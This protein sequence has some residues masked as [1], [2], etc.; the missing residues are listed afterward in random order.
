MTMKLTIECEGVTINDIE[1]ALEE[2]NKRFLAGNTSG[3]DS[4]DEGNFTFKLTEE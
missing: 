3:F 1:L 4:N 2:A